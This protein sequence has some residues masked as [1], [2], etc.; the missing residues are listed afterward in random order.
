MRLDDVRE[1]VNVE[2]RRGIRIGRGG[3]I[4]GGAVV[5]ALVLTLL[6]APQEIVQ[7]VLQG[8]GETTEEQVPIDPAQ[9]P[10]AS[11]MLRVLTTTEETWTE[12]FRRN[13]AQYEPPKLV[14][15]GETVK[16]AC[17]MAGS[18]V[19]PFYCPLDRKVYLD[20]T[21]FQELERRFGAPGD[22]AQG[23]VLA[24][25]VGH[26]VQTLTGVSQKVHAQREQVSAEEGNRLSVRQELQADCYAGIWAKH[27]MASGGRL[28]PGDI[29]EGLKAAEAIGD[30]TIQRR[31]RG[32]VVPESF[33]HGTS[34]QRMTWFRRGYD[35]GEVK[36]CDT[37]GSNI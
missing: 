15:F 25:E 14:M 9:A 10:I 6:G 27:G 13:Q 2:D 1:S 11:R 30:D 21:F 5:V 29:E 18:A 32:R 20:L 4:G 17:G 34:A 37:F 33:T 28:D 8:G 24:H 31:A 16:S 19:G 23:Y 22:F 35:T 36:A 7:Q 12:I 26:H 3:A